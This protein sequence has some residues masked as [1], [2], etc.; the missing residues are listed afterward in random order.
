[1]NGKASL[2]KRRRLVAE[3]LRVGNPVNQTREL[4]GQPDPRS[5]SQIE[6]AVDE[7]QPYEHNPRRTTNAKFEDIK[8]SI[9]TS[10]LRSP[11]TVTRR[12]GESHFI[13]EA[14]GN[15]R[16]LA[17]RQ[18]WVETRDPRFRKLVVLYR[19]WRSESH[20][21]TAHLI[22]NEQ[23]GEMTFWDKACGIVALKSRLEA[24]QARTLTLR[25]LED[26]LHALGLAVN[27]A[28]L[29]LYLFAT[30]RLRTLGEAVTGISGLD[31]KTIQPRL[32]ALKRYA[33]SRS[34]IP[35][36]YLYEKV[37]E[38]A[39][40]RIAQQYRHSRAFSVGVTCEACE[41]ALAEHLG[42]PVEQLRM[43][44]ASKGVVPPVVAPS[45]NAAVL[46]S[47]ARAIT[48]TDEL[49]ERVRHFADTAGIADLVR[50]A[51]DARGRVGIGALTDAD[52]DASRQR[53]WGLL[54]ALL[55][56]GSTEASPIGAEASF[57]QW[58]IDPGD[59]SAAAFWELL[60]CA[61][62]SGALRRLADA[63]GLAS[64]QESR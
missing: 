60:S 1:M 53:A 50:S 10:G 26:A 23:R 34:G 30:E 29:G 33:Q 52:A 14:G 46:S 63:H 57:L 36:D 2:D 7:I 12:P 25:P 48:A 39:F 4:A 5:E 15:T 22:E 59:P 6:L 11:L 41:V 13:A 31:V 45:S 38:P 51:P 35:E 55:G 56:E 8:E 58:L 9:R 54:A 20:V 16:L 27:T 40:R 3:S 24:E 43:A 42:E 21:L 61:R 18:L 32:N 28:T 19:P 64:A 49:H 44:A 37:F 47:E 17:L 62:R